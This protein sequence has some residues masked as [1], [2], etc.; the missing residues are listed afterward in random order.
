MADSSSHAGGLEL[1]MELL[2]L[3]AI[4]SRTRAELGGELGLSRASVFRL[5][6]SVRQVMGAPIE[7]DVVLRVYRL[8]D[9]WRI[10]REWLATHA[11]WRPTRNHRPS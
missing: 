3:L 2:R 1:A 9:G 5:I 10:D 11:P 8:E 6:R 7:W 4:S